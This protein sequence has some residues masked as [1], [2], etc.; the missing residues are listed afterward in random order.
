MLLLVLAAFQLSATSASAQ[1]AG[2]ANGQDKRFSVGDEL[3]QIDF[4]DVEL[5]VVIETIAQIT[6][7]NFIYD[8]RV[9]G[10]KPDQ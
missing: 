6:G 7:K 8:D 3:V 5:T 4:K 2:S 1:Q 10:Q 9:R